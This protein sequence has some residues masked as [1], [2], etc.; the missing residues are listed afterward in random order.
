MSDSTDILMDDEIV[1]LRKR[2]KEDP[3]ALQNLV[4]HATAALFGGGREFVTKVGDLLYG[5]REPSDF[6]D[7]IDREVQ[8]LTLLTISREWRELAIHCYWSILVGLHPCDIAQTLLLASMGAGIDEYV[9]GMSVMT[10]VMQLLKKLAPTQPTPEEV[11]AQ[12][13]L[14]F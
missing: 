14:V 1:A 6:I 12:L 2:Y 5:Q 10:K 3:T 7:P 8:L 4:L 13:L 9:T 11:V